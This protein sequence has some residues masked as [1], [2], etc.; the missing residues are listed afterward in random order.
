[1]VLFTL[2]KGS[3]MSVSTQKR[4][5]KEG[6]RNL[7]EGLIALFKKKLNFCFKNIA[8]PGSVPVNITIFGSY[9]AI[10][11]LFVLDVVTDPVISLQLLYVFPIILCALHSPRTSVVVGAVAL[12]I[13]LQACELLFFHYLAAKIP[14]SNFL[15]IAFSNI[16]CALVARSS[17]SH[18]LEVKRLSTIDPLTQLCNRRGFDI[19]METEAVRQRR[20]GECD[21]HFSLAVLDLDGFKGLNDSKGHKAG[22]E[23]LILLSCVLR[24]LFRQ[25]DTI[26][27]LGGDEFAVLMPN[28]E[29]ADCHAL[30]LLLCHTIQTRLTE[31]FSCQ[32][33]ASIGFTTSENPNKISVDMLTVADKALYQ[34]KALGKNCVARGYIEEL[35]EKDEKLH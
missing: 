5:V 11:L 15:L 22:D 21:G 2:E 14:I 31:A 23:A 16:I 1:M 34:A 25:T 24:N 10:S 26:C 28:T 13:S 9:L 18:T 29:A 27:R 3:I 20:K 30:C 4:Q 17:R 7:K 12:S 32:I 6:Y 8:S 19:A 35:N 33:S